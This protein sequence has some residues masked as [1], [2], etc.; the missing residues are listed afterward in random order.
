MVPCGIGDVQMSTV[1]RECAAAGLP[2]PAFVDVQRSVASAFARVFSVTEREMP[3][4]ILTLLQD[5]LS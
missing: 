2:V 1:A 4:Q 5:S 3:D